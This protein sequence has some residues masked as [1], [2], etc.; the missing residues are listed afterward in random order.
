MNRAR[1][2]RMREEKEI[3][4]R[5]RAH[6]RIL[7]RSIAVRV[8]NATRDTKKDKEG[9]TDP[10]KFHRLPYDPEPVKAKDLKQKAKELHARAR[11]RRGN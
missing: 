1:L 4:D 6:E 5:D 7:I 10:A 9:I 3:A 11:Q 2:W 8:S